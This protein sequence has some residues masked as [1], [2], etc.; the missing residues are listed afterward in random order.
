MA[1]HRAEG[2]AGELQAVLH[3]DD[4][5][6]VLAAEV[7]DGRGEGVV[8]R[9]RHRAGDSVLIRQARLAG[10]GGVDADLTK[11]RCTAAHARWWRLAAASR[12]WFAVMRSAARGAR[13]HGLNGLPEEWSQ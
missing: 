11:V 8:V 2:Q 9:S 3:V 1:A 10:V 4:G 7:P 5:D 13:R 6:A 12:C